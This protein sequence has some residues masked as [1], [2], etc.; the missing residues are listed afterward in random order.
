MFANSVAKSG[1]LSRDLGI[2][3]S[4]W[5][6]FGIFIFK[7]QSRDFFGIFWEREFEILKFIWNLGIDFLVNLKGVNLYDFLANFGL[8]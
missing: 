4:S 6:F 7:S 5:D 3:W 8:L 1:I 2:F